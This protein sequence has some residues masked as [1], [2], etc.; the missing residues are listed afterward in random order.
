M[1]GSSYPTLQN[2]YKIV[3]SHQNKQ[4]NINKMKVFRKVEVVEMRATT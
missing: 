3:L 4:K 1:I 2:K